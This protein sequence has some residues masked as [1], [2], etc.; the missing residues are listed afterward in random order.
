MYHC[1]LVPYI[2]HEKKI[3][4]LIGKKLC[5]SSK[6]GFI[7]NNPGQFVFIGGGCNKSKLDEKLVKSAIREFVEETGNYVNKDNTFLKRYEDFSV[8]YYKVTSDKEYRIYQN[9]NPNKKDKWV[10]ISDLKW[11]EIEK[12]ISLMNPKIKNNE[13]CNNKLNKSVHQYI[14]DWSDKEWILKT[15][16]KNFKRYIEGKMRR[17]VS[18]NEYNYIVEDVRNKVK[19]SEYYDLMYGHIKKVFEKK[20]YT[21]WY[22]K[23]ILNL[24]RNIEKIDNKILKE[25]SENK[26]PI[27][28]KNNTPNKTSNKT[29]NKSPNKSKIPKK[30]K[31]PEK[32][33]KFQIR[34]ISVKYSPS[35]KEKK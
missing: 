22:H 23:M 25:K 5:Y 15:E 19:K 16:M 2:I 35:K 18:P 10:E 31:T 1:Y 29:P 21:D 30:T 12:A 4:V 28:K 8:T 3:Y 6:D 34:R 11:V 26:S 33:K 27:N 14:K 20:S 24:K 32:K 17:N 7:H 9:I 13:P